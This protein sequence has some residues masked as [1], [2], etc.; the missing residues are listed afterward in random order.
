MGKEPSVTISRSLLGALC[1]RGSGGDIDS[2]RFTWLIRA[3]L[4]A[5]SQQDPSAALLETRL[6]PA[7]IRMAMQEGFLA[8]RGDK[9]FLTGPDKDPNWLVES[10]PA[11]C[12]YAIEAIGQ[13]VVKIGRT[14]D[15]GK[16]QKA[17]QRGL[18]YRLRLIAKDDRD[19]E[20]ELHRQ[21]DLISARVHGEWFRYDVHSRSVISAFL[22]EVL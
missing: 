10:K 1:L 12:T 4:H 19:I 18:P 14:S 8:K 22:G 20:A 3:W 15:V 6:G 17:L 2:E 5:V 16:R 11:I 7:D 13:G 9:L 21:L